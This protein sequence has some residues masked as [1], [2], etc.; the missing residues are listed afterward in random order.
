MGNVFAC[1]CPTS[2]V[3]LRQQA[4]Q[5]P[6]Y[7]FLDGAQ[8]VNQRLW[9]WADQ[10]ERVVTVALHEYPVHNVGIIFHRYVVIQTDHLTIRIDFYKKGVRLEAYGQPGQP[11][12]GRNPDRMFTIAHVHWQPEACRPVQGQ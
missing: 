5:D 2:S 11:R 8:Q 4:Q 12:T 6:N 7:T 1:Q 9:E 10:E 3:N